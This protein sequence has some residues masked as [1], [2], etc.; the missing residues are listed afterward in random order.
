[1]SGATRSP[2]SGARRARDRFTPERGRGAAREGPSR[3]APAPERPLAK[4]P[5]NGEAN[6]NLGLRGTAGCQSRIVNTS[7]PRPAAASDD[8][9][10]SPD[11][12]RC[13]HR[14]VRL[15]DALGARRRMYA[16]RAVPVPAR[17]GRPGT[18]RSPHRSE[19]LTQARTASPTPRR[20]HDV[21]NHQTATRSV[22]NAGP[23]AQA[24][25]PAPALL[26]FREVKRV[27]VALGQLTPGLAAPLPKQCAGAATRLAPPSAAPHRSSS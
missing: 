8:R 25:T 19:H 10:G 5:V 20:G 21:M 4:N 23:C 16:D 24:R 17:R 2:A 26:G 6:G 22:R 13:R 1:L 14:V 9:R 18:P 15:Q 27:P 12:R 3:R 7:P 11:A